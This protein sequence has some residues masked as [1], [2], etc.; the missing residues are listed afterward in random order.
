MRKRQ[1]EGFGSSRDPVAG[2]SWVL[3]RTKG[4]FAAP[5]LGRAQTEG[6]PCRAVA[7]WGTTVAAP[8]RDEDRVTGTNLETPREVSRGT[9]PWEEA[10][11]WRGHGGG[12]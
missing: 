2:G 6:R 11:L 9:G 3:G 8:V 1:E 7:R 5:T 12:R 4:Q 10:S